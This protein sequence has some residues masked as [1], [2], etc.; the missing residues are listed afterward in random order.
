MGEN[1]LAVFRRGMTKLRWPIFVTALGWR[2]KL[3]RKKHSAASISETCICIEDK[4]A[5]LKQ[6][7]ETLERG[8]VEPS[9][10]SVMAI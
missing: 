2:T 5:W 1:S 6:D 10:K 9:T 8:L 4:L 3:A 7:V